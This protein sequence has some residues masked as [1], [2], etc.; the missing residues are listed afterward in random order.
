MP[1]AERRSACR[2]GTQRRRVYAP[3][4]APSGRDDP[5]FEHAARHLSYHPLVRPPRS[6]QMWPHCCISRWAHNG[7]GRINGQR[8]HAPRIFPHIVEPPCKALATAAQPP[9]R[10]FPPQG[11]WRR[12][13]YSCISCIKCMRPKA[14]RRGSARKEVGPVRVPCGKQNKR[15]ST[16]ATTTDHR[17][18][19]RVVRVH[20]FPKIAAAPPA[21][22]RRRQQQQQQEYYD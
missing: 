1:G 17:L 18:Q 16:S 9:G 14:G 20:R 19:P 22:P 12:A 5:H 13:H 21:A 8:A 6:R 11:R 15:R 10:P 2:E 7:K 3:H 4:P